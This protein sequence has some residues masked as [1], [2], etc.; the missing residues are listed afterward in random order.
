MTKQKNN[1]IGVKT[2]THLRKAFYLHTAKLKP[3]D[4]RRTAELMPDVRLV[5]ILCENCDH[6]TVQHWCNGCVVPTPL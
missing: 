6:D 3:E 1:Q 2:S 5:R 4:V